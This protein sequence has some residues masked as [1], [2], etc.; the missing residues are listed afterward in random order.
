MCTYYNSHSRLT[1]FHQKYRDEHVPTTPDIPYSDTVIPPAPPVIQIQNTA[2]E[3]SIAPVPDPAPAMRM[4]LPGKFS[5]DMDV[6][7]W[8]AA[9]NRYI[10]FA[11]LTT[12]EQ[13]NTLF[14]S[15][16]PLQ[17]QTYFVVHP[18]IHTPSIICRSQFG[19]RIYKG[20]IFPWTG[21]NTQKKKSFS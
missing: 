20:D 12:D 3:I 16:I 18:G 2:P 6:E 8:I 7:Q 17:M 10:S 19:V 9:L 1:T 21:A 4:P 15:L 13:K 14:L 5:T 11:R